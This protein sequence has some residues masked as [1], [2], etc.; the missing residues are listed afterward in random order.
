M[1]FFHK[2]VWTKEFQNMFISNDIIVYSSQ[3]KLSLYHRC[4]A[5]HHGNRRT[6]GHESR[7]FDRLQSIGHQFSCFDNCWH[8]C[9]QEDLFKWSSWWDDIPCCVRRS[10]TNRLHGTRTKWP[11]RTCPTRAT[12]WSIPLLLQWLSNTTNTVNARSFYCDLFHATP[13]TPHARPNANY[14]KGIM[15]RSNNFLG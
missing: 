14:Q 10:S 12:K 6:I 5:H 13:I 1:L 4:F 2:Q 9:T 7:W 8:H 3:E 11:S 15:I